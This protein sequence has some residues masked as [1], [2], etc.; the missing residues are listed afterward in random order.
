MVESIDR[1]V[2]RGRGV[3]GDPLDLEPHRRLGERIGVP[4]VLLDDDAE[5]VQLEVGLVVAERALHEQ[6]E[7]RLGALELEALVLHP[8][9]HVEDPARLGRVLVEVDAVLLGLPENVR[10]PRQLGHGHPPVIAHG[11]GIDVLVRLGMLEDGR[12]VDA[13]LV[14]EG[15]VPDVRLRLP[16]LAIGQ[17]GDEARDVA[18]LAQVLA[19]DA[20]EAHLD[21]QVRDDGDEVGVAAALAVAVDGALD[22]VHP[23][24]HRGQRVGDG[25]LGVVVHVDAERR[26][27]LHVLLDLA[28][29]LRDLVR[30]PSAIGVAEDEAVRARGLCRPEGGQ[31]IVA[32][33]LEAVE[34]VLGVVDDLLEVLEEI[35]DGVADHGDVLVEGGPERVGDVKVP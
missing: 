9:E 11:L 7:G 2:A 12:D 6:L 28:D 29:D 19:W 27:C 8:L 20:V 22:V 35:D 17:L 15:G 16:R 1:P 13:P 10:L 21:H 18:E 3:L 30:Q 23:F 14:G 5:A 34:E 25:A 4:L 26:L 31:S 24:G 32:V 33:L